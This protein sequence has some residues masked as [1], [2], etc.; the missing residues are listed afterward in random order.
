[1]YTSLHATIL[2]PTV[3]KCLNL[4]KSTLAHATHSNNLAAINCQ[5]YLVCLSAQIIQEYPTLTKGEGEEEGG[6]SSIP[7]CYNGYYLQ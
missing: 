7:L 3:N 5:I 2:S 4:H 6:K 1:M